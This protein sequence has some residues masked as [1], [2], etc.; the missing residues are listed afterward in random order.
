M[1]A[2]GAPFPRWWALHPSRGR[3]HGNVVVRACKEE[4]PHPDHHGLLPL[5]DGVPQPGARRH[6]HL[7]KLDKDLHKR[8]DPSRDHQ[9]VE[10]HHGVELVQRHVD[11]VGHPAA[12]EADILGE[13][14]LGSAAPGEAQ[15]VP[16]RA[17]GSEVGR[18]GCL[19]LGSVSAVTHGKDARL[20]GDLHGF[21][22]RDG[23]KAGGTLLHLRT[24]RQLGGDLTA[25]LEADTLVDQVGVDLPP[26][27]RGQ[28]ILLAAVSGPQEVT[29]VDDSLPKDHVHASLCEPSQGIGRSSMRH[30]GQQALLAGHQR[31]GLPGPLAH[32]FGSQ[33]HPHR[34]SPDDGDVVGCAELHTC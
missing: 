15:H 30:A 10:L 5:P 21:H 4:L 33:L 23:P 22:H 13:D 28:H 31:H 27:V 25:G 1:V 29:P 18:Q 3:S 34:A 9:P 12:T 7:K 16:C 17:R 8:G 2:A 19:L 11:Y 32:D 24:A 26:L 6:P 20:T 14:V